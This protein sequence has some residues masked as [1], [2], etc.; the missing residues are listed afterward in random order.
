MVHT[1][2]TFTTSIVWYSLSLLGS[3]LD[4]DDFIGTSL[5]H[6]GFHSFLGLLETKGLKVAGRS[7]G[8]FMT[9]DSLGHRHGLSLTVKKTRRE[10]T[11]RVKPELPDPCFLAQSLHEVLPELV[12]SAPAKAREKADA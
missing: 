10:V 6:D 11:D 9:K 5:S 12:K 7:L 4:A 1:K 2:S 8:A 3:F